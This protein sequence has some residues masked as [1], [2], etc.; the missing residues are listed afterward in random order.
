MST[1]I[2]TIEGKLVRPKDIKAFDIDDNGEIIGRDYQG[3]KV[4]LGH[5]HLNTNS[6]RL[7]ENL[8][9]IAESDNPAQARILRIEDGQV[10]SL[11]Y[12]T[13]CEITNPG[14]EVTVHPTEGYELTFK[15]DLPGGQS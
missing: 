3:Y 12:D 14:V 7:M 9:L 1:L 8:V 15:D 5:A 4:R 13:G 11:R 10:A 6:R 2:Q